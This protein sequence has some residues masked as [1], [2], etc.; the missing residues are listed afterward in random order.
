MAAAAATSSQHVN[1]QQHPDML[2]CSRSQTKR[3]QGHHINPASL[4]IAQHVSPP[5]AIIVQHSDRV[6]HPSP[7][8]APAAVE[9]CSSRPLVPRI[10]VERDA[11]TSRLC[12]PPQPRTHILFGAWICNNPLP[13]V[14]ERGDAGGGKTTMH[15]R[16]LPSD[17]GMVR[18]L[19]DEALA[20]SQAPAQML[21]SR[22]C[23]PSGSIRLGTEPCTAS[24]CASAP[25]AE[26][27]QGL[28]GKSCVAG[29]DL[30]DNE[31]RRL[32]HAK[33]AVGALGTHWKST[34]RQG[35]PVLEMT[36]CMIVTTLF[37]RT[38]GNRSPACPPPVRLGGLGGRA[39]DRR[40]WSS[41]PYRFSWL[42]DG[43][44]LT[45]S[46]PLA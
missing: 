10:P 33:N 43:G 4:E 15:R 11:M 41:P 21:A 23:E 7:H 45:S 27:L 22:F 37:A 16:Q 38:S 3:Q 31:E 30:V 42:I 1:S 6:H 12:P 44:S 14:F 13:G 25:I 9:R 40:P 24:S 17:D 32:G 20:G 29:L 2:S 26:C 19:D 36:W 28:G 35:N 8:R 18:L 5:Q 34:N 39:E 46:V